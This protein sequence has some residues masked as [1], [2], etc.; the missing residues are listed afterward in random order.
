[1]SDAVKPS[2]QRGSNPPTLLSRLKNPCNEPER[3]VAQLSDLLPSVELPGGSD[4]T[5]ETVQRWLAA[6]AEITGLL[7]EAVRLV[8]ALVPPSGPC[9]EL[10]APRR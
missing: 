1:M 9:D 6:T 2:S 5:P 3:L 10:Q 7:K 4:R 8:K